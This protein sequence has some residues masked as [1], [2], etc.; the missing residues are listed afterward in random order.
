MGFIRFTR[1][2]ISRAA[3]WNAFFLLVNAVK[4]IS[5]ISASEIQRSYGFPDGARVLDRLPGVLGDAR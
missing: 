4:G 3:V 2:T 5:V 1:R